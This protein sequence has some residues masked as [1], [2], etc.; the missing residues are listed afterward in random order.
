MLK[1]GIYNSHR[2]IVSRVY[3][4]GPKFRAYWLFKD[5]LMLAI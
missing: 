4:I 3:K 2:H 5:I 1:V